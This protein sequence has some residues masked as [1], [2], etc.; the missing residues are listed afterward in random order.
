[1]E[2]ESVK[3]TR[4][5]KSLASERFRFFVCLV[6]TACVLSFAVVLFISLSS[7]KSLERRLAL[8]E[9]KLD[10]I[11]EESKQSPSETETKE[12]LSVRHKRDAIPPQIS[13]ADLTTRIIALE[14]R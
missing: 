3:E 13:L 12:L 4:P 2:Q 11:P 10:A 6:A 9:S 8:V 7:L 5:A 1:M 14:V